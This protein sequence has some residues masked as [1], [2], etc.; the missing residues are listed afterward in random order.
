MP[1]TS[2]RS[3]TRNSAACGTCRYWRSGSPTV[4]W[5]LRRRPLYLKVSTTKGLDD[6]PVVS[7]IDNFGNCKF[8]CEPDTIGFT[9]GTRLPVAGRNQDGTLTVTD[10]TCYRHLTDVPRGAA[11]LIVGSSGTG[12]VELVVRGGSAAS[13][14]GLQPG[15]APLRRT[16]VEYAA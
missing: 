7:V 1:P 8:D 3:R 4:A 11:G 15:D 13:A 14:F 10:V 9:I 2:R 16:R 5:S 6:E 12:F